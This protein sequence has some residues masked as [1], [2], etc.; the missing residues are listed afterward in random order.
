LAAEWDETAE[1]VYEFNKAIN[2]MIEF[3][4]DTLAAK[5]MVGLTL[6]SH[7]YDDTRTSCEGIRSALHAM[8]P[9]LTGN[10]AVDVAD[11]LDNPDT[12]ISERM[13]WV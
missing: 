11:L 2:D 9:H 13:F 4:P 3:D 6:T 10:I 7:S 12:P 8:R 1:L 5:L